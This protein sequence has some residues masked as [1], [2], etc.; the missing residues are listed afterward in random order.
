MYHNFFCQPIFKNGY[1][2]F[3]TEWASFFRFQSD[4]VSGAWL[5]PKRLINLRLANFILGGDGKRVQQG[6][7]P[8]RHQASLFSFP[9]SRQTRAVMD[10]MLSLFLC[11][12]PHRT[13]RLRR[14]CRSGGVERWTVEKRFFDG[15]GLVQKCQESLFPKNCPCFSFFPVA[16]A[17]NVLGQQDFSFLIC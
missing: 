1:I 5:S 7:Y 15:L 16:F 6:F 2:Y 10:G 9:A 4:D 14:K 17:L 13:G 11:Q 12:G 3:G 8:A